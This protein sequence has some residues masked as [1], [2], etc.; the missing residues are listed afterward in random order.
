MLFGSLVVKALTEK[1]IIFPVSRIRKVKWGTAIEVNGGILEGKRKETEKGSLNS[2]S[3]HLMMTSEP[4]IPRAKESRL[5]E[6]I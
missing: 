3:P 5:A 1:L 6:V 2:I 4:C